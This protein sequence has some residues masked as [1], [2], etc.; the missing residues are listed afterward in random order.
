MTIEG[1]IMK[2]Q[3]IPLLLNIVATLLN[4]IFISSIS[5]RSQQQTVQDFK[6]VLDFIMGELKNELKSG[7]QTILK[8]IEETKN[9][10]ISQVKE[11]E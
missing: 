9:M 2:D 7:Q 1:E 11:S 5:A 8:E 6:T 3:A 4:Y 10:V